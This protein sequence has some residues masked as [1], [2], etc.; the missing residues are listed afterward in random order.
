MHSNIYEY[1]CDKLDNIP[2]I[3]ALCGA[4]RRYTCENA[5]DYEK[6][7]EL[8]RSLVSFSGS[9]IYRD[10]N[11][12]VSELFGE[13]INITQSSP[14]SLWKG[15]YGECGDGEVLEP[16]LSVKTACADNLAAV[17]DISQATDFIMP[18]KYHAGLAREKLLGGAELCED[19]KNMLHIQELREGAQECIKTFN[20]LVI[21]AD[22]SAQT[23][24]RA[25]EYLKTCNLLTETLVLISIDRLDQAAAKMLE[26]DEITLGVLLE[27]C[28]QEI[29]P[30]I[31]SLARILPVGKI[32]WILKKDDF[33]V[34]DNAL[35]GLLEIWRAEGIAPQDCALNFE[36]I[37]K[38]Y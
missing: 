3:L 12:A 34:F 7:R 18:D 26:F 20:P 24:L 29:T 6:F 31:K 1:L 19:E 35:T 16:V 30:A 8:C 17:I 32:A 9:G 28:D 22:C 36:D 14:E 33:N 38:F 21:R 25:L 27:K 13:S 23:T 2:H 15:F 5:S 37:C 4:D 11:L 10:V